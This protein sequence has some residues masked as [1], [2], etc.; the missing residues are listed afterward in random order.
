MSNI[1]DLMR[2][3]SQDTPKRPTA[4]PRILES[5]TDQP[6]KKITS[7]SKLVESTKKYLPPKAPSHRKNQSVGGAGKIVRTSE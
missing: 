6:L 7:M 3:K 4:G 1:I 5:Q 2:I